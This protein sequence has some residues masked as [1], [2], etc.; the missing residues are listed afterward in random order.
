MQYRSCARY[1]LGKRRLLFPEALEVGLRHG[2]VARLEV[3]VGLRSPKE[4]LLFRDPRMLAEH[5]LHRALGFLPLLRQQLQ[6]VGQLLQF[7]L[8][9]PKDLQWRGGK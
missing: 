6:P 1:L 7:Q 4:G 9:A 8:R 3:V 5:A 2:R